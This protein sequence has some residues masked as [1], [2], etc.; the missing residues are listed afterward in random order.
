MLQLYRCDQQWCDSWTVL[1]NCD[2][3]VVLLQS[4]VMWQLYPLRS[5]VMWQLY[6]CDQTVMWQ[7]YRCDQLWCNS[8]N[9]AFYCYVIVIPLL[10]LNI[11]YIQIIKTKSLSAV[12]IKCKNH[13]NKAD[14]LQLLLLNNPFLIFLN[15]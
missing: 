4:T 13:L 8:C 2:V 3:T 9:I 15:F 6:S 7:L 10:K 1:I 14:E 11:I 12:L 5:T